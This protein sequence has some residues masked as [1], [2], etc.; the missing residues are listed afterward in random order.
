LGFVKLKNSTLQ[1]KVWICCKCKK[2][3]V[4]IVEYN[5]GETL[6]STPKKQVFTKFAADDEVEIQ[7]E[8]TNVEKP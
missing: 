8:E 5:K 7:D 1:K 3:D 6:G 2:K 4:P